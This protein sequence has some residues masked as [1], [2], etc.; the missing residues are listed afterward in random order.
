MPEMDAAKF[1]AQ[2]LWLLDHLGPEGIIVTKHGKP[3]AKV[4]PIEGSC[5]DLIG[6]LK[7][8]LKLRGDLLSTGIRWDAES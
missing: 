8:K 5:A 4:V 7:G 3:V 2:C 6:S 1:K